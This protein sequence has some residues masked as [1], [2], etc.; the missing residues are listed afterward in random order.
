[1]VWELYEPFY[2]GS[3]TIACASTAIRPDSASELRN[4]NQHISRLNSLSRV[5]LLFRFVRFAS[6]SYYDP[7]LTP[8]IVRHSDWLLKTSDYGPYNA[9]CLLVQKIAMDASLMR[10]R[11]NQDLYNMNLNKICKMVYYAQRSNYFEKIDNNAIIKEFSYV[12]RTL[13]LRSCYK[14]AEGDFSLSEK[15]LHLIINCNFNRVK[16]YS[17]RK[18]GHTAVI[19]LDVV[20]KQLLYIYVNLIFMYACHAKMKGECTP[21]YYKLE[22]IV[23]NKWDY[24]I[25]DFNAFKNLYKF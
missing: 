21:L 13:E 24:Y 22:D 14:A 18:V 11:V 3:G 6:S 15:V 19:E 8:L 2:V 17:I 23:D 12:A 5:L 7:Q 25:N 1:M 10:P 16:K 9:L 20:E 4:V